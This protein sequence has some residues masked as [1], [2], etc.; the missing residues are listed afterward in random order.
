M[1]EGSLLEREVDQFDKFRWKTGELIGLKTGW[2][3]FDEAMDGLQIGL[4]MVG[5]KWNVGKSA[6]ITNLALRL[7]KDPN[8]CILY[9]S[10]DDPSVFK[11]IPRMISILS[12][13]PVNTV[14]KPHY[15]IEKNETLQE[16]EKAEM[17]Y[18]IEESIGELKSYAK[19][20][21]LKD[22][23]HGQDLNF[24]KRKIKLCKQRALDLGNKN[25]I[26][27][28][29]FLHMIKTKNREENAKLI[30]VAEQLKSLSTIYETPIITTVMGTK[31]GMETK[32]VKD[33]AIKGAVELQYEA[34]SIT[35]LE[36]DFYDSNS[37]LYFYDDEGQSRPIISANIAKNK[38]SGFRGKL[39]YKFFGETLTYKECGE[40]GQQKFRK[41]TR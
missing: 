32:D 18:N 40:E 15:G 31:A 25:L 19:R 1:E 17:T 16:N 27:F 6:F 39:F 29:D 37:R 34:D 12:Q 2:Q 22:A 14:L 36:T 30:A 13:V 11:T 24:I 7:L 8:N 23:K 41:K 26:V 38:V 10:I 21:S 20:F 4:H 35:L 3:F 5:G 33:T 28:V 9:F